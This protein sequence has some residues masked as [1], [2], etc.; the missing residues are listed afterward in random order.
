MKKKIIFGNLTLLFLLLFFNTSLYG[1]F[2]SFLMER[3]LF[4]ATNVTLVKWETLRYF[5]NFLCAE[6]IFIQLIYF[7]VSEKKLDQIFARYRSPLILG[8]PFLISI[9]CLITAYTFGKHIFAFSP[10]SMAYVDTAKNL[11]SGLGYTSNILN[12]DS[13]SVPTPQTIWPPLFPFLISLGIRLGLDPVSFAP[14]MSYVLFA[15]WVFPLYFGMK[16]ILGYRAAIFSIAPLPAFMPFLRTVSFVQSEIPFVFFVLCCFALVSYQKKEGIFWYLSIGL[17]AGLAT[18]T[19][20]VGVFLPL[21]IG[22][23]WLFFILSP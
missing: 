20:Y 4:T 7:T 2:Y 6:I 10:D 23:Y 14:W 16:N 15:L 19:R 1:L 21:A 12:W 11:A 5:L 9:L 22:L 8:Y 13:T 18:L 3:G 17:L